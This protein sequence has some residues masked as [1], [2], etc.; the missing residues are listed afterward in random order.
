MR[1]S[2]L[3]ERSLRTLWNVF[4]VGKKRTLA[5]HLYVSIA[6]INFKKVLKGHPERTEVY[7]RR[8]LIMFEIKIANHL[9]KSVLLQVPVQ[10][11]SQDGHICYP[12]H[13]VSSDRKSVV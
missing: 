12:K 7:P 6:P 2:A 1:A 11:S 5:R 9:R 3:A 8:Y 4:V 10:L 13:I